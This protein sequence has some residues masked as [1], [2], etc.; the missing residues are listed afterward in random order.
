[1]IFF[2]SRLLIVFMLVI[3]RSLASAAYRLGKR[4]MPFSERQQEAC[5]VTWM[6]ADTL[7]AAQ[8]LRVKKYYFGFAHQ[9]VITAFGIILDSMSV[10]DFSEELVARTRDRLG[11]YPVN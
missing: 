1:M 2:V 3:A 10:D 6:A 5:E 7:L 8:L 9:A 11:R 4:V